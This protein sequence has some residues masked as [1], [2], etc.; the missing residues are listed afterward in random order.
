MS[1]HQA[2]FQSTLVAFIIF[3]LP[4]ARNQAVNLLSF[5]LGCQKGTLGASWQL[6]Q[7]LLLWDEKK[8]QC[9]F[10]ATQ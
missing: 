10:P 6:P 7:S 4:K 8:H 2:V 1:F 3:E 5:F 9:C